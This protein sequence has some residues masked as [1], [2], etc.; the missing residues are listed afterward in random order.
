[1]TYL[2]LLSFLFAAH[3][4]QLKMFRSIEE[5]KA[6]AMNISRMLQ[7]LMGRSMPGVGAGNVV[8]SEIKACQLPID[9]E[10]GLVHVNEQLGQS[11]VRRQQ[12]VCL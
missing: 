2:F 6:I 3:D 11:H 8:E 4:F 7:T 5:V 9:S 12:M 1:M 10:E